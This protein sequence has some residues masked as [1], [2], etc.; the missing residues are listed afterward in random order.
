MNSRKKENSVSKDSDYILARPAAAAAAAATP[1]VGV[2]HSFLFPLFTLTKKA[3]LS[4]YFEEMIYMDCFTAANRVGGRKK[5]RKKEKI[6]F[7][8]LFPVP[9]SG[10]SLNRMEARGST[11]HF[12]TSCFWS[13]HFIWL[14]QVICHIKLIS[15]QVHAGGV[16]GCTYK[17]TELFR[18]QFLPTVK[19]GSRLPSGE[20]AFAS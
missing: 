2:R 11:Y 20:S 19:K 5:E 6:H 4:A 15:L 8:P 18:V 9:V 14:K 1:L 7:S 17:S 12:L 10:I 13:R 16:C 3:L